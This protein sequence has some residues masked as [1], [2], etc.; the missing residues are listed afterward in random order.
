MTH[1]SSGRYSLIYISIFVRL[2]CFVLF[3]F[4]YFFLSFW[5]LILE[6]FIYVYYIF[7]ISLLQFSLL[8]NAHFSFFSCFCVDQGSC[9][10]NMALCQTKLHIML[11]HIA[12]YNH[13]DQF[14][15][16]CYHLSLGKGC[17]DFK[18]NHW[19]P[20]TAYLKKKV[21]TISSSATIRNL[22]CTTNHSNTP[23]DH[24]KL[25]TLALKKIPFQFHFM[26]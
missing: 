8:H 19:K 15:R 22:L 12:D 16:T 7:L 5:D 17:L 9:H 18:V 1:V 25:H 4:L 23:M 24:E 10:S 26:K 14:E 21:A 13:H 20:W 11:K 6:M 2:R 3:P